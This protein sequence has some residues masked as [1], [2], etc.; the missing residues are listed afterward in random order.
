MMRATIRTRGEALPLIQPTYADELRLMRDRKRYGG[1]VP[2]ILWL[3]SYR[4]GALVHR[5]NPWASQRRH[6]TYAYPIIGALARVVLDA[7]RLP[8][9]LLLWWDSRPSSP[10][11]GD[12][13]LPS[14]LPPSWSDW[15]AHR[16]K[17][18]RA[19]LGFGILGLT[20]RRRP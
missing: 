17:W 2:E 14:E 19:R 13:L 16:P 15:L 11:W 1:R 9:A 18:R 10:V 4:L 5:A 6:K 12:A 3:V 7:M 20:P 8:S